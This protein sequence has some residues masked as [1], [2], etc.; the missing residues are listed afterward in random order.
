M[1]YDDDSEIMAL[2]MKWPS[3]EERESF[4]I[5]RFIDAYVKL[6]DGIRFKVISKGERPDY[7]VVDSD[8]GN[9]YGL[10]LTSVYSNDRSVPES[11]IPGHEGPVDIPY[12][13]QKLEEYKHRIIEKIKEK[14]L[15]A[16]KHYDTSRPLILALYINEY[17][18]IYLDNADL[19]SF[20]FSHEGL[21]DLIRPFQEVALWNLVDDHVLRIR[22]AK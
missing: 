11:H 4:E 17:I 13:E 2:T 15:K 1:H 22:L 8:T 16:H 19:E 6:P 10:E 5:D 21:L 9:E 3:K 18:S 14:A 12:N 7:T 20:L